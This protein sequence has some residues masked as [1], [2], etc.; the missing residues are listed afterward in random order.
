MS[1]TAPPTCW[2]RRSLCA[3]RAVRASFRRPSSVRCRAPV[4]LDKFLK[5]SRLAQRRSEAHEALV[6]GQILRDGRHMKP[7]YDV[8][9][10]DVLDPHYATKV[11]TVRVLDNQG[12]RSEIGWQYFDVQNPPPV[13]GATSIAKE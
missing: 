12:H 10:G 3:A 2:I 11:L 13:P 8:K 6:A 9:P 1:P 4:R 5:V 7:G